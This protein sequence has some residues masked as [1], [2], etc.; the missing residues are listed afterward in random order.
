LRQIINR[1]SREIASLLNIG[2]RFLPASGK[3]PVDH[4]GRGKITA[5]TTTNPNLPEYENRRK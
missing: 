1:F 2:R 4:A 5:S 3:D